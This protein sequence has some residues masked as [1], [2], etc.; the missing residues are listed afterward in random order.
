MKHFIRGGAT[1]KLLG[2]SGTPELHED[3]EW[4]AQNPDFHHLDIESSSPLYATLCEADANGDC[5]LPAKV[6]LGENLVYDDAAKTGSEYA[7]DTI[8][9]VRMKI[10]PAVSIWYEYM[11]QPC[12][13]HAFYR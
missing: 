4:W 7:V 5:T 3:H 11:R 12:V 1:Y 2:A 8:R 13:E 10:G 9:T 6:V